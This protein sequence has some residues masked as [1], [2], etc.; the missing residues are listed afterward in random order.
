MAVYTIDL[1]TEKE[2]LF[3]TLFTGSGSTPTSGSTYPEVNLFTDLPSPVGLS[4]E[5]YVVR[6]GSGTY[7]ADRKP[8]GLYFSNGSTWSHLGETTTFFNANN[9]RVF[10]NADNDKGLRFITSGITAGTVRNITIQNSNGIMAYLADVNLKVNTTLFNSFTGTTL[11][12]AY[13][14]KT[15]IN[16]YTGDTLTNIN[17]RLL[18]TIFDTFTGTTLPANYYNKTEI[19]AYTGST[20]KRTA[21]TGLTY[22]PVSTDRIIGLLGTT[23]GTV[24]VNL[25]SI[26]AIG[27]RAYWTFKDEG[28][29]AA[30]NNIVFSAFTGNFIEKTAYATMSVNGGSITIY[31][32]GATNWYIV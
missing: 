26:S 8:S 24:H 28:F 12:A 3:T 15:Q 7:V 1:L 13:Y 14:N 20:F 10:D 30:G 27:N 2:Y 25:P 21:V 29:N 31:N 19:N 22:V 11:P 9:F 17:T 32:D 23:G 16:T 4:G 5:I 18:T 6:S